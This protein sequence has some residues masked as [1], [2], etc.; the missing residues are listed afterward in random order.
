MSLGV[1]AESQR[2]PDEYRS[3]EFLGRFPAGLL[4]VFGLVVW[5]L[6]KTLRVCFRGWSQFGGV[7]AG[8]GSWR[9]LAES[10]RVPGGSAFESGCGGDVVSPAGQ[11]CCPT[12]VW[13]PKG[14]I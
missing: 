2:V 10:L 5:P 7:A 12:H 6:L 13:C 1:P 9:V 14:D 4:V 11:R 8:G 3:Q